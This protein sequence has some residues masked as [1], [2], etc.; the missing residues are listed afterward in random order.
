MNDLKF[1]LTG[2][3]AADMPCECWTAAEVGCDVLCLVL[4]W[5]PGP[6]LP[7]PPPPV[8]A[9]SPYG[10]DSDEARRPPAPAVSPS[11]LLRCPIKH[12]QRMHD[13]GTYL[14]IISTRHYKFA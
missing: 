4:F 9:T 5:W 14:C 8:A 13:V 6:V 1:R 10:T 7:W 12:K 2:G 3:G 11:P